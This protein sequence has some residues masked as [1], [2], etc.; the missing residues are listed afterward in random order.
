VKPY[1]ITADLIPLE[2]FVSPIEELTDGELENLGESIGVDFRID[3]DGGSN[4]EPETTTNPIRPL[5]SGSIYPSDL[6]K[7]TRRYN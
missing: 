3:E 6:E 5:I 4:D 2:I 7:E 1:E